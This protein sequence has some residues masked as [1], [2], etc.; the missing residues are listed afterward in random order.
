[1]SALLLDGGPSVTGPAGVRSGTSRPSAAGQTPASP[2]PAAVAAPA[3]TSLRR[4]PPGAW[5]VVSRELLRASRRWQTQAQR[6]LSAG[7]LLTFVAILWAEHVTD[8]GSGFEGWDFSYAGRRIFGAYTVLQVLVLAALTPLLVAQA[9]VEEKAGRTMELLATTLLT[10]ARFILGKLLSRLLSLEVLVLAGLPIVALCLSLG[11]VEPLQVA[12]VLLQVTVIVIALG[13]VACFLALYSNGPI[14]PAVLSWIW[15]F[16]FFVLGPAPMALAVDDELVG[17]L[18]PILVLDR[19]P[20]IDMVGPFLLWVPVSLAVV[21]VAAR[22]PS[23]LAGGDSPDQETLSAGL[24]SIERLKRRVALGFVLILVTSPCLPLAYLL[25]RRYNALPGDAASAA[26]ALWN[27]CLLALSTL[28]FLLVCR[29]LF[30]VLGR[31]RE[32]RLS[33]RKE[34]ASWKDETAERLRPVAGQATAVPA[35]GRD[36][37]GAPRRRRHRPRFLRQVWSNPVAWRE[38]VTASHG[39]AIAWVGRLY[40]GAAL[41]LIPIELALLE[42]ERPS[43]GLAAMAIGGFFLAGAVVL[44]VA[45]SS[46]VSEQRGE[47]LQLLCASGMSPYRILRGKLIGVAAFAGP[48]VLAAGVLLIGGIGQFASD[49]RWYWYGDEPSTALE[50]LAWRW[51][52]MCTWG[53]CALVFLAASTQALALRAR[54]PGRAWVVC[55]LWAT[56]LVVVLPILRVAFDDTGWLVWLVSFLNPALEDGFWRDGLI[57]ARIWPSAGLLLAGA[58]AAFWTGARRLRAGAGG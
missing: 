15:G 37:S 21:L 42:P 41:L 50:I 29:W 6:C 55:L 20:R 24:W 39:R 31:R 2:A 28:A 9:V 11:G 14:V 33:W 40:V 19:P 51:L 10:P 27:A 47:T 4:P 54:T 49:W 52:A 16:A 22:I 46:V 32:R 38:V 23:V 45:T 8:Y 30:G 35:S 7:I 44:L 13:S 17:W 34:M 48:V 25:G 12:S 53:T 56:S 58:A 5:V 57:D 36:L 18:S 3:P 43:E 26:V 1:M